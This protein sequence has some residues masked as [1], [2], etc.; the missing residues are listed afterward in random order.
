MEEKLFTIFW[1]GN[2]NPELI[3]GFTIQ[4]AFVKNGYNGGTDF[5]LD[6]YVEGDKRTD[7]YYNIENGK[8]I[9]K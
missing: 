6:I 3:K 2:K 1:L 9:L 4:D 5:I 8:W 7:Y